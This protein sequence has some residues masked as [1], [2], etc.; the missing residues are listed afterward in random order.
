[1]AR[2]QYGGLVP[3]PSVGSVVS[4][5]PPAEDARARDVLGPD[6]E[7]GQAILIAA[8]S[9]GMLYV[10]VGPGAG[11][12]IGRA[13][14]VLQSLAIVAASMAVVGFTARTFSLRHPDA[15]LASGIRFDL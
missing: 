5:A 13:G 2:I 10:A 15:P 9:F 12:P 14:R 8:I 1:M 7:A 3:P 6:S 11:G 4:N